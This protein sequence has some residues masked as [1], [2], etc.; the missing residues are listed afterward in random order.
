MLSRFPWAVGSALNPR[1]DLKVVDRFA[2][3]GV[4]TT[5]GPFH[6]CDFAAAAAPP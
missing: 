4:A 3:L 5:H 6:M 1:A 2:K